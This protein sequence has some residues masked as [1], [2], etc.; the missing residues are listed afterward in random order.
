[1]PDA[2][3]ESPREREQANR[4]LHHDSAASQFEQETYRTV[5][6][7]LMPVLFACYIL[8]YID[9]VNVGF[10]KLQMQQDLQ[11]SD[12]IYGTAAG[13]FCIG[14]FFFEVPANLLL[15]K[16]GARFWLG[17]ITMLWGLVSAATLLVR[18]PGMFYLV[19]FLLGVVESGFFPG[20]ILYLTFWYTR[21]RRAKMIAVFMTAIPLSGVLSG[22]VSGWIL[23]GMAHFG[24]LRGWQWL[25]LCEGLPSLVAGLVAMRLLKNGPREAH[26]LSER[27][28]KLI[29]SD[30]LE[31]EEVKRREGRSPHRF[32]DAF[33]S[34]AVWTLSL[35]F[36]GFAMANYGISFWMPQMIADTVTRDPL[37]IGLLSMIPWGFGAISMV[38]VGRHSDASGERRWH[39]TI[40][41]TA[42]GIAFGVSAIPGI[43]GALSLAALTLATGGVLAAIATFWSLPMEFLS[44][45]AAA[46]GIAVINSVGNLSGYLSPLVAGRIRDATHSMAPALLVFSASCILAASMVPTLRLRGKQ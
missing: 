45:T 33:R 11:M 35:V 16:V 36:F 3:P 43:S 30:L 26:W 40:A 24:G 13:I 39:I 6:R 7:H 1:M 18:T 46:A 42:G 10:A 19:R 12:T 5:T 23:A 4:L 44:A 17:S 41:A 25:Y 15:Q 38:V 27:Q 29:E 34:R 28:K 32:R 22:A 8:S 14:Y 21:R 2:I 37:S 9:R 31:E 20:V